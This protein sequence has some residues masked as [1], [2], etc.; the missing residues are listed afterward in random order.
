MGF[1]RHRVFTQPRPIWDIGRTPRMASRHQL[2]GRTSYRGWHLFKGTRRAGGRSTRHRRA[3]GCPLCPPAQNSFA[4][5]DALG[6]RSTNGQGGRDYENIADRYC[7][8]RGHRDCGGPGSGAGNK[9]EAAAPAPP[10]QQN[11]P[12]DKVTPGPFE[13]LCV[14]KIRFC[15]IGGEGRQELGVI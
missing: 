1:A 11:A 10:A 15:N 8:D 7:A 5:R 14:P 9:S 4:W 6:E 3:A 13:L 2:V 12:P